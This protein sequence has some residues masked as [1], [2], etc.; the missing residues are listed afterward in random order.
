[1]DINHI[2]KGTCCVGV[3]YSRRLYKRNLITWLV[4]IVEKIAPRMWTLYH[5]GFSTITLW[6]KQIDNSTL[7]QHMFSYT[8]QMLKQYNWRILNKMPHFRNLVSDCVCYEYHSSW[9]HGIFMT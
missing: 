2:I 6:G 9:R 7:E 5:L 8:L 3:S 4:K 1:L